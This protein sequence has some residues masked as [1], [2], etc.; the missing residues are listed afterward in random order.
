MKILVTVLAVAF[1][2]SFLDGMFGWGLAEGFYLLL[3]LVY[4]VCIVWML[5]LVYKK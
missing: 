2:I 3:G 5:M 1:S 4:L